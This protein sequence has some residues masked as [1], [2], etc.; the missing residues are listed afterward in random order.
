M[1]SDVLETAVG[2]A[3]A[4]GEA[5][6]ARWRALPAGAVSE[7]KQNDFVTLAD[8]ESER[9]I[10]AAI[11]ERFPDDTFLAEEGGGRGLGGESRRQWIIDPLDGTSNFIAG[12]P[13]WCVSVAASER[14]ELVAGVVWD[15]LRGDLYTAERGAGAFRNG[16]RLSVTGRSGVAGAFLATGFPFRSRDRID[17]YLALFRALFLEARAIRR[18]GSAA[19]DLALVAAGVFDGFFEFRLAIWDIAAGA[20]LIEEA[21]GELTDFDGG[22]RYVERG[23]IVAGSHGVADGIRR[24]AARFVTE[25]AI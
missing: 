12:F 20:L 14:G 2:G 10:I 3:R 25:D 16:E 21:G 4:G 18:A 11:R 8:H 7:K 22:R 6:R 5:L 1:S 9:A 17:A 15:P 24:I 19:L 13:F 23:N